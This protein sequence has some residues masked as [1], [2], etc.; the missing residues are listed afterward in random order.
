[1][2]PEEKAQLDALTVR[3]EALDKKIGSINTSTDN[4][5][6]KLGDTN[7]LLKDM[8]QSI[9]TN[10][11]SNIKFVK[12]F[13]SQYQLA[14]K[15]AESYKK[16]SINIGVSR[17]NQ[18]QFGKTFTESTTLVR[19]LGGDIS[20]V[21]RIYTAFADKSGRARI[22]SPDEVEDIYS[23]EKA[24]GLAGESAAQLAERF[25]LMGVGSKDF[26]E[27]ISTMVADSQKM[28][29]NSSKVTKKLQENF[30]QMQ[31]M[32]FRGGVKGMT[33]MAKLSVKM[34]MEISDML[35]MADKFYEPE[36]A[37]E[38]S[39]N[40]QML[41]G[42]VAAAFGDPIQMMYEARNAPEELAKRVGEV[43]KNMMSFNKE[44][45]E[46]E[47]PPEARMQIQSMAESLGL[48]KDE[49]IDTARQMSKMSQ[50]K[51][52]I[53]GNMFDDDQQEK[54]A[55]LA[56]FDKTDQQ[57]K[58]DVGGEAVAVQDLNTAELEEAMKAPSTEQ[59][60]IM[61]TAKAAM[62][63]N[64][65]LLALRESFKTDFISNFNIYDQ[66]ED[67]M[68]EM[69]TKMDD[70]NKSFVETSSNAL[71]KTGIVGEMDIIADK[72]GEKMVDIMEGYETALDGIGNTVKAAIE[73][74]NW[75][76]MQDGLKDT[77][78]L[79]ISNKVIPEGDKEIEEK[80]KQ[81]GTPVKEDFIM[82]KG[83][84][85]VSFTSEDDM[86]SGKAGGPIAGSLA[87]IYEKIN[88]PIEIPKINLPESKSPINGASMKIEPLTGNIIIGGKITVSNED[89]SATSQ[90][91]LE[92]YKRDI[93]T[94][95]MD[96]VYDVMADNWDGK[97]GGRGTGVVSVPM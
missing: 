1:M 57:W 83:Q 11:Q 59:D 21:E 34:R 69:V 16:T 19:K 12:S 32:S 51:M 28:G 52:D 66:M 9:F 75:D 88:Q 48:N 27:N 18:K 85:A 15:L 80:Q 47:M 79:I 71:I 22:L 20:D 14:E 92:K 86:F 41:G 72:M 36:A 30:K 33:E 89:G 35:S 95:I 13:K 84:P 37:I 61:M 68:K 29:L 46:F 62:T 26:V 94:K 53:G 64:E 90:M 4:F 65:H 8:G 56:K 54:I 10:A 43:T 77:I 50:I 81:D 74:V 44:T 17:E 7:N 42:D 82:R 73:G 91:D 97:N 67:T 5:N 76:V 23:I 40:L 49:I 96:K 38:A 31:N 45:G 24:T 3:L 25:D 58:V 60:A 63:T 93:E 70:G 78:N 55:S 2:T 6:G 39:A 87:Q